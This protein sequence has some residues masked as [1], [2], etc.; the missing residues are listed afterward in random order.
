MN[1]TRLGAPVR[2]A[3]QPG[4][5]GNRVVVAE[6]ITHIVNTVVFGSI[7]LRGWC[8]KLG[9]IPSRLPVNIKK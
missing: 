9:S 8:P 5:T 7:P 1:L 6:R 2:I 3:I 4:K